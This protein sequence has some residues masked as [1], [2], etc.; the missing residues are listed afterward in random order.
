M[1]VR[2]ANPATEEP[3]VSELLRTAVDDA[4]ELLRAEVA[5]A[6]QE[7]R[8]GAKYA[9]MSIGLGILGVLTAG[10]ALSGVAFGAI[11]IAGASPEVTPFLF[12]AAM[13]VVAAVAVGLALLLMPKQLLERTRGR[14]EE[15]IRQLK[16]GLR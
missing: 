15:D 12:G 4:R 3:R 16:D 2:V 5:L 9:A 1:E 6:R 14:V 13:A 11:R 8:T 7:V 10:F